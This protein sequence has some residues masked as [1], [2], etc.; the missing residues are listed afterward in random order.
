MTVARELA[1]YKLEVV[2]I[3]E[4][5]WDKTGIVRARDYILSTEKGTKSS[6]GNRTYVQQNTNTS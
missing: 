1:M 6:T 4:V 2:G 5:G 3:Q